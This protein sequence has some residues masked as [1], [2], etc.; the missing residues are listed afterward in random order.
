MIKEVCVT[1]KKRAMML[2]SLCLT[3]SL[4]ISGPVSILA[5]ATEAAETDLTGQLAFALPA[6]RE[7]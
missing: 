1:M 6:Q 7:R 5:G 3:A 2:A 4:T